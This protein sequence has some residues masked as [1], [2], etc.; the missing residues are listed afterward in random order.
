MITPGLMTKVSHGIN[1]NE[2]NYTSI[3]YYVFSIVLAWISIYWFS[4][5][6]PA[7]SIRIYY[8]ATNGGDVAQDLYVQ[9]PTGIS[10]FP[11]EVMRFPK[12]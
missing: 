3:T 4:K 9:V 1:I 8:E 5:P 11:M 10:F 2:H 7:A 12:L 6:G